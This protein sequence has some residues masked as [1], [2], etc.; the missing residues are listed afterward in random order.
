ML[1]ARGV[2][3]LFRWYWILD[4]LR[5]AGVVNDTEIGHDTRTHRLS[6]YRHGDLAGDSIHQ[7]RRR[8]P[9]EPGAGASVALLVSSALNLNFPRSAVRR[10]KYARLQKHMRLQKNVR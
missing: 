2:Q 10:R 5:L 8:R 9:S 4:H 1:M 3:D 7:R 6:F